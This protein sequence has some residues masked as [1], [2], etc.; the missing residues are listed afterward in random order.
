MT[1]TKKIIDK[2]KP[3]NLE[4]NYELCETIAFAMSLGRLQAIDANRF[5]LNDKFGKA[6]LKFIDSY[7]KAYKQN[8]KI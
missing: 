6:Y 2:T 3:F 1:R 8:L 5:D 7:R 4:V